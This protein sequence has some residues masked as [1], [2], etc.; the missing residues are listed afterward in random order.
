MNDLRKAAE[1]AI[2][3]MVR[4]SITGY[5]DALEGYA[6]IL[7]SSLD[8][9]K[10]EFKE[11]TNDEIDAMFEQ[12]EI[13]IYLSERERKRHLEVY[14]FGVRDAEAKLKEKNND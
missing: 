11:L 10:Q 12:A 2:G 3:A 1:L 7:R 8:S 14:S 6:E 4:S 13:G 5:T 9:S